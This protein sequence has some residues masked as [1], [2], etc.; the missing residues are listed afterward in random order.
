VSFFDLFRS[1][2]INET[3]SDELEFPGITI[4]RLNQDSKENF[5]QLNRASA[6]KL[7][8]DLN[9]IKSYASKRKNKLLQIRWKKIA[10]I[11]NIVSLENLEHGVDM[12]F[13]QKNS[14]ID[15]YSSIPEEKYIKAVAKFAMGCE[16]M[17]INPGIVPTLSNIRQHDTFS[18]PRLIQT[19]YHDLMRNE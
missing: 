8:S 11:S 16:G 7:I 15:L 12:F 5:L 14:N 13:G 2:S 10:Q 3:S 9:I 19:I 4:S 6:N 1:G 17:D 18:P